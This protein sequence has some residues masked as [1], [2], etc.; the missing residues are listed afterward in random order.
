MSIFDVTR[1]SGS[2]LSSSHAPSPIKFTA[3]IDESVEKNKINFQQFSQVMDG[4]GE[5][6]GLKS[7]LKFRSAWHFQYVICVQR[8]PRSYFIGKLWSIWR[9]V[10][11]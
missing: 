8:N 11:Y 4:G 10:R 3:V 9:K 6:P 2:Y 5:G 1:Y 7:Y